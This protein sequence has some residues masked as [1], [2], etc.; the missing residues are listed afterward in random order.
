MIRKPVVSRDEPAVVAACPTCKGT[1]L[2]CISRFMED[3]EKEELARLVSLGFKKKT[4]T[5]SALGSL[6][7]CNCKP[8]Q[9]KPE[10]K[11][12][13]PTGRPLLSLRRG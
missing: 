9:A 13:A 12:S 11:P 2:F 8:A 5:L 7:D 10:R 3:D 6:D 4:G 1:K